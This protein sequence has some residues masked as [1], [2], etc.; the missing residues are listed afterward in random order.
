M[1]T[2]DTLVRENSIKRK[3]LVSS[4]ITGLII[5][6]IFGTAIGWYTHHFFYQ[7]RLAQILLCREQHRNQPARVVDSICGA[8]F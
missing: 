6:T 5:G 3:H 2:E 4:L 8:A 1:L 7:Q